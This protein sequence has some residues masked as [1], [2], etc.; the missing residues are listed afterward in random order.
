MRWFHKLVGVLQYRL[1]YAV[2]IGA[3]DNGSLSPFTMLLR[4]Y[5]QSQGWKRGDLGWALLKS[6][7]EGHHLLEHYDKLHSIDL[8][9]DSIR[10][11]GDCSELYLFLDQ[12]FQQGSRKSVVNYEKREALFGARPV[13]V[14]E[15][16]SCDIDLLLIAIT[17]QWP[18]LV[19]TVQQSVA[20]KIATW[21]TLYL[22]HLRQGKRRSSQLEILRDKIIEETRVRGHQPACRL[23]KMA[24]T[25][26]DAFELPDM[27]YQPSK[28]AQR[29]RPTF[30]V[31]DESNAE[32]TVFR[33]GVVP[34]G[35]PEENQDHTV[36]QQWRRESIP[37]IVLDGTLGELMLCLCSIHWDIRQQALSA[38]SRLKNTLKVGSCRH[39]HI[40][41]T[42]SRL[43]IGLRLSRYT[44]WWGSLSK[45]S[46]T[47]P[48][49]NAFRM[50][51]G[52][53]QPAVAQC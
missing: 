31:Q 4:H 24:L 50:S 22:D 37:E 48:L 12:C 30:S 5:A 1:S 9:I 2:L 17:D 3:Q 35:P 34:S 36:L 45:H 18:F 16:S 11:F 25:G 23:L 7:S 38:L 49:S 44:C 47:C 8:L 28:N 33:E 14:A 10:K 43:R 32:K 21:L 41:L 15:E 19:Q 46:R 13:L 20:E 53:W 42:I 40:L 52:R 27:S 51:Q 39:H 29:D 26:G 6:V